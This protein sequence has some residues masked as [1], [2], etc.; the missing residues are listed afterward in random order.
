MN[1]RTLSLL[2]IAVLASGVYFKNK[3][4]AK[5]D[6]NTNLAETSVSVTDYSG[7]RG[8]SGAIIAHGPSSSL[9]LT[10]KH[11]C[12]VLQNGGK[13]NTDADSAT[14]TSYTLSPAHDLCI[15]KVNKK[16]GAVAEIATEAPALYSSATTVGHPKLLPTTIINGHF[17]GRLEVDVFTGMKKCEEADLEDINKA[18][19]CLLFGGLPQITTYDAQHISGTIQA[20]NSGSPV[21]QNGKLSGVVFAGSGDFS[22]GIIVP[23]EY[24]SEFMES[25]TKLPALTPN[26]THG[27]GGSN[28]DSGRT[29]VG[30]L[31]TVRDYCRVYRDVIAKS[32]QQ[33]PSFPVD[34]ALSISKTVC[35]SIAKV[36]V[37]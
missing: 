11:V 31:D 5:N 15:V 20:G 32:S 1:R 4:S 35:A 9:I 30:D 3:I 18:V 16:I 21:Y 14:A 24:V 10:N 19:M 37:R 23:W 28:A 29:F 2:A 27:I 25:Y 36:L 17:G 6:A 8:G 7:R 34:R 22:Y 33:D 26:N 12:Q 13:V